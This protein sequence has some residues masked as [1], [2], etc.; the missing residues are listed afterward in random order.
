MAGYSE[1]NL[2]SGALFLLL[3]FCGSSGRAENILLI[4]D[5]F[6]VEHAIYVDFGR[7]H[8]MGCTFTA[9]GASYSIIKKCD[10]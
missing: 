6:L 9:L 2:G 3:R 8:G 10:L 1:D 7:T 4:N 5:V